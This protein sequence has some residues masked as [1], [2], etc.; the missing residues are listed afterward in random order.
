MAFEDVAPPK[1]KK[2][3]KEVWD[4]P[5]TTKVDDPEYSIRKKNEIIGKI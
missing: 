5:W 4:D 2:V 3:P 1:F